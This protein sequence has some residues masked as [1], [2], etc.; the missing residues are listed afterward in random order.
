MYSNGCHLPENPVLIRIWL[1]VH[2]KKIP[3]YPI[4]YLLKGDYRWALAL[5]TL[6]CGQD[7][8]TFD[9]DRIQSPPLPHPS[10][11][12]ARVEHQGLLSAPRRAQV[13]QVGIRSNNSIETSFGDYE[14]SYELQSKLPKPVIYRGVL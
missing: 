4:F 11:S 3:A 7:A 14:G 5:P 8:S 10:C 12:N 2:Y 6:L 9:A 1:W 13:L